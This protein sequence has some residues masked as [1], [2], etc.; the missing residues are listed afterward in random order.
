[1]VWPP[2]PRKGKSAVLQGKRPGVQGKMWPK[3]RYWFSYLKVRGGS[4]PSNSWP[5]CSHFV[6]CKRKQVR[7]G[8]W[9]VVL[10]YLPVGKKFTDCCLVWSWLKLTKLDQA[11]LNLTKNWLSLTKNWLSLTEI[12]WKLAK[13]SSRRLGKSINIDFHSPQIFTN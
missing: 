13:L 12:W 9:G 8:F 6:F 7:T 10:P 4:L 5:P 2:P 3:Y 11:W 1:M